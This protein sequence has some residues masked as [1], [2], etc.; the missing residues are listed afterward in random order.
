MTRKSKQ[1]D[2]AT[3]T[4]A[5]RPRL[6][7]RIVF[8]FKSRKF[9]YYDVDAETHCESFE[10]ETAHEATDNALQY[11]DEVCTDDGGLDAVDL[12][13]EGGDWLAPTKPNV[14]IIESQGLRRHF[15][16]HLY[17]MSMDE[18]A[19]RIIDDWAAAKDHQ[20]ILT[21]KY[22]V[23]LGQAVDAV[24]RLYEEKYGKR[25]R[26]SNKPRLGDF[27]NNMFDGI[28]R[29]TRD[30]N[31]SAFLIVAAAEW[32]EM[33]SQY[34]GT[35]AGMERIFDAAREYYA[36][37]RPVVQKPRRTPRAKRYK[38]LMAAALDNDAQRSRDLANQFN[39]EDAKP[40]AE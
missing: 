6:T 23:P 2:A 15:N 36:R 28:D 7:L 20:E 33:D 37:A 40:D 31:Y 11:A 21:A 3:G 25:Q 12:V 16:G 17:S 14:R 27:L 24:R 38:E 29:R 13:I 4:G 39:D 26:K 18:L 19:K 1:A 34:S 32:P 30:R 5:E 22:E 9:G 8:D 10:S 35:R